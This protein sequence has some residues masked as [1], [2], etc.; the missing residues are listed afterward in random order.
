[1]SYNK[2]NVL[3]LGDDP[4]EVEVGKVSFANAVLAYHALEVGAYLAA[5]KVVD[6]L[7][8]AP[9]NKEAIRLLSPS[10]TGH[11]EYLARIVGAKKYAM[12]LKGGPLRVILVTTHLPLSKVSSVITEKEILVKIKLAHDFLKKKLKIRKPIIGVSALN[13]HAGEGGKI[14]HEE[15]KTIEPAIKKARRQGINVIG[16]LPADVIFYSAYHGK[17][18]AVVAMYHD[19]GL[20]P[21]KM[22]AFERGVNVTLNLGFIR[23]SPDH[24]TAFDIAYTNK[25]KPQSMI[26]AIKTSIDLVSS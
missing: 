3:D 10:F 7:V 4:S 23:T 18:D 8:T 14:G 1:M 9:V 22:I 19:Q 15:I 25:A 17:L 13:P 12:L 2:I 21:L 26:E 6:A 24:G 20:G 16:P 5:H 11:T